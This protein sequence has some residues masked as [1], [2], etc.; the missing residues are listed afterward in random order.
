MQNSDTGIVILSIDCYYLFV[1]FLVQLPYLI[2]TVPFLISTVKE[3]C[4]IPD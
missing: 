1:I 2:S 4:C 3:H